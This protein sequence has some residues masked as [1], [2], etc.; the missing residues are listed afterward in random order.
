MY[1]QEDVT[2][3]CNQAVHKGREVTANWS[4]RVYNNYKQNYKTRI[5]IDVAIHT[6]G[7]VVQK[8]AKNEIKYKDLWT[9]IQRMWNLKG[10]ITPVITGIAG[11]LRFTT[12]DSYTRNII[13]DTESIVV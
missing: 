2:V 8:E 10:K 6:D 13:H 3:L 12:K 5:P 1:E 11:I 7:D 4:D 9:V